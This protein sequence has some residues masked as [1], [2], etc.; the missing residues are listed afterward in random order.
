MYLIIVLTF[1]DAGVRWFSSHSIFDYC[2]YLVVSYGIYLG[3]MYLINVVYR[4]R[5]CIF[6]LKL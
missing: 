1:S 3:G 2:I 4:Q 6:S 5:E